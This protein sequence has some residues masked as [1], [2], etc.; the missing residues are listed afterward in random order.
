MS[1]LHL[2]KPY[3]N[4]NDTIKLSLEQRSVLTGYEK[5]FV[6]QKFSDYRIVGDTNDRNTRFYA[7]FLTKSFVYIITETVCEYP[8]PYFSEKTWKAINTGCPFMMVNAR[9]SLDALRSFGFKT[10]DQWWDESYDRE[11]N[12]SDRIERMIQELEK[13]SKLSLDDL[14]NLRKEMLPTLDYNMQHLKK[15]AE[16]ELDNIAKSI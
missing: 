7:P 16:A 4:F 12:G 5:E 3:S 10:F 2:C 11:L 15:F 14:K 13:L 6:N 8:Y 1:F 9:Y